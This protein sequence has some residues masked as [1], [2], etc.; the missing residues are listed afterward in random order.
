MDKEGPGPLTAEPLVVHRHLSLFPE[1]GRM[2]DVEADSVLPWQTGWGR[3]GAAD[4]DADNP[5]VGYYL[6][7]CGIGRTAW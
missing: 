7:T 4:A 2:T 1:G 6:A 5:S 3:A